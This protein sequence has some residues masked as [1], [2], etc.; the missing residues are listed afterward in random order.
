MSASKINV[1]CCRYV[2]KCIQVIKFPVQLSLIVYSNIPYNK[3]TMSNYIYLY[4]YTFSSGDAVG[5][6]SYCN[7]PVGCSNQLA[8]SLHILYLCL[9]VCRS[10]SVSPACDEVYNI[11]YLCLYGFLCLTVLAMKYPTVASRS[12]A[13]TS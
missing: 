6:I 11:L 4:F 5:G 1:P 12:G 10:F 7:Q 9:F 13:L 8:V 3:R 2:N